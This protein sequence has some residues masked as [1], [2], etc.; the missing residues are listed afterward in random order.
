MFL[1]VFF[2]KCEFNFFEIYIGDFKRQV[3]TIVF[4]VVDMETTRMSIHDLEKAILPIFICH[5]RQRESQLP[6]DFY[7]KSYKR[8]APTTD[9]PLSPFTTPENEPLSEPA[10]NEDTQ[11]LTT[12]FFTLS[13]QTQESSVLPQTVTESTLMDIETGTSH[14]SNVSQRKEEKKT[15]NFIGCL[16]K[17]FARTVYTYLYQKKTV[18][19]NLYVIMRN[20]STRESGSPA[21][22]PAE[23]VDELINDKISL[24]R[25]VLPDGME[26]CILVFPWVASSVCIK[27]DSTWNKTQ[28]NMN[29]VFIDIIKKNI[30]TY[31][32][33]TIDTDTLN[34]CLDPN[35]CYYFSSVINEKSLPLMCFSRFMF[36]TY[37]C[38]VE[39]VWNVNEFMKLTFTIRSV[40][41]HFFLLLLFF[42]GNAFLNMWWLDISSFNRNYG[43]FK[44]LMS[45]KFAGEIKQWQWNDVGV[46]IT[47]NFKSLWNRNKKSW[48]LYTESGL[49]SGLSGVTFSV[50]SLK[51]PTPER[52]NDMEFS[53]L[54]VFSLYQLVL[55]R[56]TMLNEY[57]LYFS[58]KTYIKVKNK[59]KG[60]EESKFV[61]KERKKDSMTYLHD[62]I[63]SHIRSPLAF[64]VM[65][66]DLFAPFQTKK[67]ESQISRNLHTYEETPFRKS[68][69]ISIEV[70]TKRKERDS[71]VLPNTFFQSCPFE[72]RTMTTK[73]RDEPINTFGYKEVF[74][75]SSISSYIELLRQ[76][77]ASWKIFMDV[78]VVRYGVIKNLFSYDVLSSKDKRERIMEYFWY[79]INKPDEIGLYKEW[80]NPPQIDLEFVHPCEYGVVLQEIEGMLIEDY[81]KKDQRGSLIE[82]CLEDKTYLNWVLKFEKSLSTSKGGDFMKIFEDNTIN[83]LNEF[84]D[85]PLMGYFSIRILSMKTQN[86]TKSSKGTDLNPEDDLTLSLSHVITEL[87]RFS[88]MDE[89]IHTIETQESSNVWNS[90]SLQQRDV[91]VGMNKTPSGSVP[92]AKIKTFI[93]HTWQ[94]F[95]ESL[96][97]YMQNREKTFS[98][99]QANIKGTFLSVASK[100]KYARVWNNI[101]N[102]VVS[103]STG[104]HEYHQ[105]WFFV[106][107]YVVCL[108]RDSL[109]HSV[110]HGLKDDSEKLLH[111]RNLMVDIS[112]LWIEI[113]N[114][115]TEMHQKFS[116]VLSN[117]F[118]SRPMFKS[119]T[120]QLLSITKK[121]IFS[122]IRDKLRLLYTDLKTEM[123][124]LLGPSENASSVFKNSSELATIQK[125]LND[126]EKEANRKV[127]QFSRRKEFEPDN[128]LL[129]ASAKNANPFDH[130]LNNPVLEN[131][132]SVWFLLLQQIY[133]P[134]QMIDEKT[135]EEFHRIALKTLKMSEIFLEEKEISSL[136]NGCRILE[137]QNKILDADIK[138]DEHIIQKSKDMYNLY[139]IFPFFWTFSEIACRDWYFL[140]KRLDLLV[141]KKEMESHFRGAY[142]GILAYASGL[143]MNEYHFKPYVEVINEESE[144]PEPT[145]RKKQNKEKEKQETLKK[146]LLE[147]ETSMSMLIEAI[148]DISVYQD[149]CDSL[150]N[151]LRQIERAY[152]TTMNNN[153][154]RFLPLVKY[155]EVLFRRE[156][157]VRTHQQISDLEEKDFIEVQ[158]QTPAWL[159]TIYQDLNGFVEEHYENI[160]H[161]LNELHRSGYKEQWQFF[162]KKMNISITKDFPLELFVLFLM[163]TQYISSTSRNNLENKSV[164]EKERQTSRYVVNASDVVEEDED[165]P[166][167]QDIEMMETDVIVEEEDEDISDENEY[168]SEQYEMTEDD[169]TKENLVNQQTKSE[170]TEYSEEESGSDTEETEGQ[171]EMSLI[172]FHLQENLKTLCETIY[173]RV[174]DPRIYKNLEE[175]RSYRHLLQELMD[176]VEKKIIF[177]R[178][179][180]QIIERKKYEKEQKGIV[181]KNI[182]VWEQKLKETEAVKEAFLK[183]ER[184][185]I[186]RIEKY[187]EMF[188]DILILSIS[189]DPIED[190][191]VHIDQVNRD[192]NTY[193]FFR[194]EDVNLEEEKEQDLPEPRKEHVKKKSTTEIV[195]ESKQIHEKE[196]TEQPPVK[197]TKESPHHETA[198]ISPQTS[199]EKST[200]KI[201]SLT[202]LR[203]TPILVSESLLKIQETLRISHDNINT[204]LFEMKDTIDTLE[205]VTEFLF[206]KEKHATPAER[207]DIISVIF[208][209]AV[210]YTSLDWKKTW[211]A[212]I[213]SY[214]I[215]AF[216]KISNFLLSN[217][218]TSLIT[219][220][221]NTIKVIIDSSKGILVFL[222]GFCDA[223]PLKTVSIIKHVIKHAPC[224]Q[225][226][227]RLILLA[228]S[229]SPKSNDMIFGTPQKA[230][231]DFVIKHGSS[232]LYANIMEEEAKKETILK[233]FVASL[234]EKIETKDFSSLL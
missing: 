121:N 107:I 33:H 95:S 212:P 189:T 162:A 68:G 125:S 74:S 154:N 59:K 46:I 76:F 36:D 79:V 20:P 203:N 57:G 103:S 226:I 97:T 191:K 118:H 171:K 200:T 215:Q 56:Y 128:K 47:D 23:V 66:K 109:F 116:L 3:N 26:V 179:S 29:K 150:L 228:L 6:H 112:N 210:R 22:M 19:F 37:E 60:H 178:E 143:M 69:K 63:D 2:Q 159:K 197:G 148:E 229:C 28:E 106:L 181:A 89:Q 61:E 195:F 108:R 70:D 139:A 234:Q 86:T 201:D 44:A 169:P 208:T 92:L 198:L 10:R 49:S 174:V 38:V 151:T 220:V 80:V 221:A 27:T 230:I 115:L 104:T 186:K 90:S 138:Q 211:L 32:F 102:V 123:K 18:F 43:I 13:E 113:Y 205:K 14:P 75:W 168:S 218:R 58:L 111:N 141:K 96:S 188:S 233:Q 165:I 185:V 204:W 129:Q 65:L 117:L 232:L 34:N 5:E 12:D 82:G 132:L 120:T 192:F 161:V 51:I 194:E 81:K 177:F 42:T 54:S 105:L 182:E 73:W 130:L 110:V 149:L 45:M 163:R 8:K 99:Q 11:R 207:K 136:I 144:G 50:E 176:T 160:K 217:K 187:R 145:A 4:W 206:N 167:E 9:V 184:H 131:A 25:E 7:K 71:L 53:F 124:S 39:D 17:N 93:I 134:L 127:D 91:S 180:I 52:N 225:Y 64:E 223:Y 224:E 196:K 164:E 158:D 133:V 193:Q 137:L 72:I 140:L 156:N 202:F 153:Q 122:I 126:L 21:Y 199:T 78:L 85:K 30:N 31:C 183:E 94:G 62:N 119:L 216:L 98:K 114:K 24:K 172:P 84:R 157:K 40:Q 48:V 166:F 16:I 15:S 190:L 147:W 83:A 100:Q 175:D 101:Y 77:F 135:S 142:N 152:D 88:R 41:D 87:N 55:Q 170:I 173:N 209:N 222:N 227:T 214:D 231:E 1:F 213:L 67:E 219:T 35:V 155:A 146:E